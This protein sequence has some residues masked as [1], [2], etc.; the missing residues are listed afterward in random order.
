MIATSRAVEGGY[1]EEIQRRD[2]VP[3]VFFWIFMF[4]AQRDE[5]RVA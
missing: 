3:S 4:F 5:E 1:A 2:R